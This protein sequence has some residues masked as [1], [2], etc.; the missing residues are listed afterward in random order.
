[1][2]IMTK[3]YKA[4]DERYK[5]V[6]EKGELWFGK[7]PSEIVVKVIEK[8]GVSKQSDILEIGCGEGRDAGFLLQNGYNVLA[9]DVSKQAITRCKELYKKH[10]QSF[11]TLDFVEEKLEQRFDFIYAIAVLHMLVLDEDRRAFYR[12][13]QEHLRADGVAL[14]TTMG[15]G[16]T[17]MQT[18]CLRAFDIVERQFKGHKIEV[19]ATS[20]R[21]VT[22]AELVAESEENSL[23]VIELGQT[24]IE[25]HFPCMSYA[26][27]KKRCS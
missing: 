7:N 24:Q 10:S 16:K 23:D 2:S 12:F 11:S 20:C 18:D 17:Q 8:Y 9:T 22:D 14:I 26:V 6:H 27:V 21:M 13:I 4:Y 3:Y 1:M 5:T 19:V 25:E 15:D